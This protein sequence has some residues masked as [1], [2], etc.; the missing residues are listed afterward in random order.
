MDVRIRLGSLLAAALLLVVGLHRLAGMEGFGVDWG[1]PARWFEHTPV[2]DIVG[3]VVLLI[4]LLLAYWL[5]LSVV[6]CTVAAVSGR[7]WLVAA[8]QR[9]A[10]PT[11]RRLIARMMTVSIAASSLAG[12][13]VPALAA[14]PVPAQ[15]WDGSGEDDGK[16]PDPLILPPHLRVELD[17]E[18]QEQD[19][20]QAP[21]PGDPAATVTVVRGDNLW[22]LS[23]Q[24][25][26]HVWGRD[27][28]GDHEVAGYWV[29][30]IDA[31]RARL[32]SGNPDL[33]YPGEVIVLPEAPPSL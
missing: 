20:E 30:V 4:A 22:R 13:V 2:E 32:R 12:P 31:N 25:L 5:L 6:A 15:A 7:K 26:Q 29:Q 3:A 10:L 14:A 21:E 1:E 8:A 19:V 9:F 33:I 16:S 23:E 11:V 24:H 28:L 27:D 18:E 17:S